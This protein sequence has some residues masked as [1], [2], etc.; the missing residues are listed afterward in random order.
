[1]NGR[2]ITCLAVLLALLSLGASAQSAPDSLSR[3]QL[4][5]VYNYE[6]IIDYLAGK[7]PLMELITHDDYVNAMTEAI[8]KYIPDG[9]WRMRSRCDF[10]ISMIEMS[11]TVEQPRPLLDRYLATAPPDSLATRATE[12]YERMVAE[13][14]K[15]YPGD[16][17]PDFTFTD[18]SGKRLSLKSLRG[19]TLLIDIW[20][21]WC[22]PCIEEMPHLEKLQQ[23]Y[24]QRED[25]HIMSIACDK[26][27]DRW[28]SFLSKHPTSWHQYL[29][30]PEG[31]TVLTETYHVMGIPRFIIVDRQGKIITPDA[32][33]PSDDTFEAYFEDII[34]R[35][36]PR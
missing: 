19:K 25:V 33:R 22:V 32:M 29:I 4:P 34:N 16:Q 14:G 24:A 23:K 30:T 27:A 1:M 31:D 7:L 26:K 5:E 20:G 11:G 17:A 13:Y 8:E 9:E 2:R 18:T 28:K 6:A 21:T 35:I 15:T 36:H 12:A 3:Q 10:A